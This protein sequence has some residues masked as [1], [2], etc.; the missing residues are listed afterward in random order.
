VILAGRYRL[1]EQ[2]GAGGM[3]SVWRG[4]DSV[5]DR[6]VAVKLVD[7]SLGA[8]LR[9]RFREE[10]RAAAGLSHPHIV[11]VHDYG[12]ADGTPYIVMELLAGESLADRL[13]TG[14]VPDAARI[15]GQVAAALAAA[16][17]AGIVHRDVKPANIF[18]T[19]AGA[20][21]LDFGIAVRGPADLPLG[22]PG[23]A[24]PE[25]L[26]GGPVTAAV[27]VYAL[28]IVLFE[29][30]TGHRPAE[31]EHPPAHAGLYHR[32]VAPIPA[33]RPAAAEVA[34]S[35][36]EPVSLPAPAPAPPAAP[37]PATRLL[38][39]PANRSRLVIVAALAV[40]AAIVALV[41]FT[42]HRGSEPPQSVSTTPTP[43]SALPSA[44]APATGNPPSVPPSVVPQST[45][46]DALTRMRRNVD[47][48]SATGQ[49]RTDVA[50]D[51]DNLISN[52]LNRVAAGQA[53][54][55]P[56][57]VTMLRQK[58]ATRLGEHGLTQASA[59]EL[60]AD[61]AGI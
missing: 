27:D 43:P 31:S 14:P 32:C 30:Q 57:Q 17:Q 20:K 5:L 28:G 38:P 29:T 47:E 33:D 50:V 55:L 44:A 40:L 15:C 54:D 45:A 1:E 58:I 16:H 51:F 41:G 23:Y 48:G 22:T 39:A 2:I 59:D 3:G 53:P 10:A 19:P 60:T 42:H 7:P 12:E 13:R 21:V 18:L 25:V 34:E 9:A 52:L 24:A 56:A 35:L 49:V 11:T 4:Q 26:K 8:D 36:G 61:L 46:I 6:Q 37:R